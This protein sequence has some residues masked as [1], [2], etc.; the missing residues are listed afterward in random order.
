[1]TPATVPPVA[2]NAPGT[3]RRTVRVPDDVWE[4]AQRKAEERGDNLSEVIRKALER[5]ANRS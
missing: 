4:A 3:P 5:Y 1:M 2:P